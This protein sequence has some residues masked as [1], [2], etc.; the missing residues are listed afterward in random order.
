LQTLTIW[1][2]LKTGVEERLRE[3]LDLGTNVGVV[4]ED[5]QQ[6]RVVTSQFLL[7]VEQQLGITR[8]RQLHLGHVHRLL[9]HLVDQRIKVHQQLVGVRMSNER[10]NLQSCSQN[11]FTVSLNYYLANRLVSVQDN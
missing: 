2:L 10:R 4:L 3:V 7:G 8:H 11:S 5:L 9:N 1:N 6:Q